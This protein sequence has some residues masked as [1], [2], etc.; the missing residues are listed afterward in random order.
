M[1]IKLPPE[2]EAII[3]VLHSEMATFHSAFPKIAPESI[4]CEFGGYAATLA[5]SDLPHEGDVDVYLKIKDARVIKNFDPRKALG[6]FLYNRLMKRFDMDGKNPIFSGENYVNFKI[7]GIKSKSGNTGVDEL[8][9]TVGEREIHSNFMISVCLIPAEIEKNTQRK[10]YTVL[11]DSKIPSHEKDFMRYLLRDEIISYG[12]LDLKV[13]SMAWVLKSYLKPLANRKHFNRETA[14]ELLQIRKLKIFEEVKQRFMVHY[15]LTEQDLKSIFDAAQ[16]ALS[17]HEVHK[18]L[19]TVHRIKSR[20]QAK[21]Q[22]N[23]IFEQIE[24]RE[25]KISALQMTR[26][27][28]L[29]EIVRQ[30]NVIQYK[31]SEISKYETSIRS[32]EKNGKLYGKLVTLTKALKE[33]ETEYDGL[34]SDFRAL[35][36]QLSDKTDMIAEKERQE[37]QLKESLHRLRNEISEMKAILG[38]TQKMLDQY[39]RSAKLAI[40]LKQRV[41]SPDQKMDPSQAVFESLQGEHDRIMSGEDIRLRSSYMMVSGLL[42]EVAE[43]CGAFVA[44]FDAVQFIKLDNSQTAEE[45]ILQLFMEFDCISRKY[46]IDPSRMPSNMRI[47]VEFVNTYYFQIGHNDRGVS[48]QYL[49]A[50]LTR[51]ENDAQTT[52]FRQTCHHAQAF[53]NDFLKILNDNTALIMQFC[54]EKNP[55]KR[56]DLG[57]LSRRLKSLLME[58][59]HLEEKVQR[60]LFDNAF[61]IYLHRKKIAEPQ[62]LRLLLDHLEKC[63]VREN[64]MMGNTVFDRLF[65]LHSSLSNSTKARIFAK[66]FFKE[67]SNREPAPDLV[68]TL[69]AYI[70]GV[71][72]YLQ[73]SGKS[74]AKDWTESPLIHSISC[75]FHAKGFSQLRRNH[76]LDRLLVAALDELEHDPV[77][78]LPEVLK[79]RVGYLRVLRVFIV[80]MTLHFPEDDPGLLTQFTQLSTTLAASLSQGTKAPVMVQ[81]PTSAPN[82]EFVLA[83]MFI[84]RIMG[85]KLQQDALTLNVSFITKLGASLSGQTSAV[86]MDIGSLLN[87]ASRDKSYQSM[88]TILEFLHTVSK[89]NPSKTP[90]ERLAPFSS[91]FAQK[92]TLVALGFPDLDLINGL[93]R[94]CI[95][96]GSVYAALDAI[97]PSLTVIFTNVDHADPVENS[98]EFIHV[99][100]T[101]RQHLPSLSLVELQNVLC[102]IAL[103]KNRGTGIRVMGECEL[104]M[105]R[106][107]QKLHIGLKAVSDIL[108]DPQYTG[109]A[110]RGPR[111]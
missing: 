92:K 77:L 108:Q 51:M 13:S 107:A 95:R 26:D 102:V 69:N 111:G 37:Q 68:D 52:G 7:S 71:K 73:H 39:D 35:N 53:L 66:A 79:N 76:H 44:L 22:T 62:T 20:T 50:L 36:K 4:S 33:K 91:F 81:G 96:Y 104:R 21:Q 61:G 65:R 5:A 2:I 25:S 90:L 89:G 72:N 42:H 87:L 1:L 74:T 19:G 29:K 63:A 99:L 84:E 32:L 103:E 75:L 60:Q 15:E 6:V 11:F 31:D 10:L 54:R 70:I 14:Q 27:T 93:L 47:L 30:G 48:F 110:F 105:A 98:D 17:L 64:A 16:R 18:E 8:D 78:P 12:L 49:R 100:N 80:S 56:A 101:I 86:L 34:M 85:K 46:G 106:L 94:D 41:V 24:R 97:L 38:D 23:E 67:M 83:K 43:D 55:E 88:A 9:V 57:E 109:T 45:H 59:K 40:L 82:F 58:E 28:L 3:T